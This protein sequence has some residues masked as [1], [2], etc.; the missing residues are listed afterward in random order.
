MSLLALALIGVIQVVEQ[1]PVRV[2]VAELMGR[3]PSEVAARIGAPGEVSAA[4][5][6]R[7]VEGGRTVELYPAHRFHRVWPEGG[8]CVTGFPEVPLAGEPDAN[9][10]AELARRGRGWFVFENG[11]LT[12]VRPDAPI[13]RRVEGTE[14]V[15]AATVQAMVLG[16]Q[17]LSPL[18]V[19]PGR[20]P[21][22]DGAGV[23]ERLPAAPADLSVNSL[24]V[25]LPERGLAQRDIGMDVIWGM[26]GLTVLP[27]VPFQKAEENRADRQGGALLDSVEPGSVL[28]GGVET[29]VRRRR[30]V[31]VYR[32]SVDP[33][34]AVIAV[35]LGNGADNI[36]DLGLLGVRGDQ[37]VWKVRRDY[38][39]TGLAPLLCRDGE[40]R[41]DGDRAGCTDYGNPRP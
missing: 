5:G 31:R 4:D 39:Q 27:F 8:V 6:I 18:T 30:G 29:F 11:V 20:L 40:N 25:E 9:P 23:L 1:P 41:P 34:F 26:V 15:S 10:R 38:G 35:K 14:P 37:V 22:S 16:P 17:P 2:P 28:T 19:A 21:L 33:T 13:P 36:A 12:G 7:I 24:C 3:T 32:D